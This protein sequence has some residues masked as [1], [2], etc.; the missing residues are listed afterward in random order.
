MIQYR[1]YD[2][3]SVGDK[4]SSRYSQKGII[5]KIENAINLPFNS[6]GITPDLLINPHSFP[7]RMTI[8]HL[9]EMSES[10]INS[11]KCKY[12]DSTGFS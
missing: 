3:L 5:G 4:L 7:S 10:A 12:F 11:N 2:K 1:R 6:K 9:I 8:G